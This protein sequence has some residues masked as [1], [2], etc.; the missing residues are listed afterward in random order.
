MNVVIT[1]SDQL[2]EQMKQ[3]Y[4]NELDLDNNI[5]H[6]KFVVTTKDLKVIAYQTNK[7]MF[8]GKDA[9]NQA[10][11]WEKQGL[12]NTT[13]IN[14]NKQIDKQNNCYLTTVDDE[15][16]GSD[17]VGTGDYFGPVTV[18]ACYINQ[19]IANKVSFLNIQDSKKISDTEIRKIAHELSDIV[20]H[21]IYCLDNAKYNEAIK[22]NNLNQ[23]KA[24]MHN[25]V[26]LKLTKLINKKP[27]I[28]VDQFCL[29]STY[30]SY[31]SDT[32]H[33]VDKICFETKAEDKYLA[34]AIASII[35]RNAFLEKMDEISDTIGMRIQKGASDLVDTQGVKI[36]Q[37]HGFEILNEIAKLHFANTKKIMDRLKQ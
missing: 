10:S 12:F 37:I 24:K 1:A 27:V 15:Y 28:I 13:N 16:I 30:Y 14:T 34:V 20:P 36:V 35:A 2:L 31:L 29:P 6:T 23:I 7:V 32:A 5:P 8:Q 3:Y 4:A 9:S 19:E 21:V 22:S 18:C 11:L 26:L 17:E 25:Y 33:V